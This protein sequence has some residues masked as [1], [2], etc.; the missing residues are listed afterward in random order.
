MPMT[1]FM[2]RAPSAY[3]GPGSVLTAGGSRAKSSMSRVAAVC[4]VTGASMNNARRTSHVVVRF[5]IRAV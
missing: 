2:L 4:A 3:S 1:M 5:M